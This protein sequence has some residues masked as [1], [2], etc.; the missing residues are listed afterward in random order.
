MPAKNVATQPSCVD[1]HCDSLSCLS[2]HNLTLLNQPINQSILCWSMNGHRCWQVLRL[3]DQLQSAM[4]LVVTKPLKTK[5]W[6]SCNFDLQN[7]FIFL[8]GACLPQSFDLDPPSI[9]SI[10]HPV[11]HFD[12]VK[13]RSKHWAEKHCELDVKEAG[14]LEPSIWWIV[15]AVDPSGSCTSIWI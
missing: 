10:H 8:S 9:R 15:V 5:I 4:A 7:V 6:S 12:G 11:T 14:S 3:I 2:H 1:P 13:A